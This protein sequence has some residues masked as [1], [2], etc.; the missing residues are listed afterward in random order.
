MITAIEGN[1]NDSNFDSNR[2]KL[3][4]GAGEIKTYDTDKDYKNANGRFAQGDIVTYKVDA[5]KD[6]KLS[7]TSTS[8]KTLGLGYFEDDG[9]FIM[10]NGKAAI[11]VNG[12]K[13]AVYANSKTVFVI[14]DG[15][16]YKV[17]TGIN[18]APTVKS[19]SDKK[20]HSLPEY[21]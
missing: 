20:R 8:G 10:E 12:T 14:Y 21:S 2:V 11:Q 15:D 4:T 6:V 7:K 5:D 13:N 19:D 1:R 16:D 9:D 3:L 18:N 17:Y